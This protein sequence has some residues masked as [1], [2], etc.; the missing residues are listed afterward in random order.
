MTDHLLPIA[1]VAGA[2]I[3]A[4]GRA[5]GLRAASG[6]LA[7]LVV[8][9]SASLRWIEAGRNVRYQHYVAWEALAR[10]P[11]ALLVVVA[12][13]I[14]VSVALVRASGRW[15]PVVRRLRPVRLGAVAAALFVASAVPSREL[16]RYAAELPLAFGLLLLNLATI[17]LA[18]TSIPDDR[19]R[20]AGSWAAAWLGRTD[21]G[22][23]A[24]S[25]RADCFA[26]V[27]AAGVTLLAAGLAGYV[28]E[29][30]PH[31]PDEVVYLYHARYF[32]EGLLELPLPP[33]WEAFEIDLMSYQA[34]RWFSPVPPGWPAVLAIGVR[35]GIPWLVNPILA[36]LGI[37]LTYLLVWELYDRATARGA[38]LLLGLSPWYLFTAMSL[39]THTSGLV[40]ALAA[41]WA[42]ARWRRVRTVRWLVVAGACTGIVSLIRPLEAVAVG[43]VIGVG[44]V[45]SVGLLR[46]VRPGLVFGMAAITV[47]AIV[48]PYN[49]HLTGSATKFPLMAYVDAKYA[50]G[51]NDLGFGADRGLG[52]PLDPF[53]GHGPHDAA[54]NAVLNASATN[55]ELFGW[56]GGS[57]VAV[58]AFVA[59]RRFRPADRFL[60]IFV[61]LVVG[62]H[63]LY[64]FSGGPDFGARYWFLIIV[65]LV[66][67]TVRFVNAAEA[68]R[69]RLG[70]AAAGLT[71]ASVICFMPWRALDKYYG[72]RGARPDIRRIAEREELGRVLV[73]VRGSPTDYAGAAAY[74]PLD[75]SAA[76]PVYAWDRGLEVRR[77]L[78][79]A[80][81]D[82]PVYLVDGPAVT[83]DGFRLIAGPL[84]AD[85]VPMDAGEAPG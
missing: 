35:L 25:P 11:I 51:L 83:G 10:D 56:A 22:S 66:A 36:G 58:F 18:V 34:E 12:Q 6:W 8:G 45:A 43:G 16:G 44:L 79:E 64:W 20:S 38:I 37:L 30:H 62:L 31:L 50:P 17:A 1:F 63:S 78:F 41:G 70:L 81:A 84:R 29:F 13:A 80:Y 9:Q 72:Y 65:P 42:T 26:C 68:G 14:V 19:L 23:P 21:P 57:L 39:M 3:L 32:A 54:V 74:N 69:T 73:L 28:Y 4:A 60:G 33:V 47:G 48:L 61:L 53:P 71:L 5:A 2:C 59:F 46:A 27:A 75:L 49:A 67:L 85:E 82:R 77:R 15:M 7:L 55:V 40:A 52:W 76:E 24:D